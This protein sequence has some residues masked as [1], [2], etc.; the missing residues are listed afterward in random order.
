MNK[1]QGD[2]LFKPVYHKRIP[3]DGVA[4]YMEGIWVSLIKYLVIVELS[5][6]LL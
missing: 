2:Y 4:F 6:L 3:T 1:E 5:F